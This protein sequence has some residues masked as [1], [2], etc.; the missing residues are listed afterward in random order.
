[1]RGDE[2][3]SLRFIYGRGGSGKSRFCLDD[4][5]RKL[6]KGFDNRLILLVPEQ[7]SF[8]AEKNLLRALGDMGTFKTEVLSFKRMAHRVF[9]EVGGI[10]HKR[11]N[12]SG[13]SMILYKI[14]R[15]RENDLKIFY[16]SSSKQGFIDIV[17]EVIT[18]FKRYNI[19]PELLRDTIEK[20]KEDE[21]ELKYKLE[22]LYRVYIDFE[23]AIHKNYI[24]DE[25][26]LTMLYEK[27]EECSLF[28]GAEVWVDE[29]STFTPQQYS[30]LSRLMKK[31]KRV[32]ISLNMDG[33]S[34]YKEEIDDIFWVAR[35]TERKLL[36]IAEE[37]HVA[38][39]KPIDLNK[40]CCYRF[41]NS[42]D[43]GHMEKYFFK[44]PFVP[45][46]EEP[47]NIRIYKALNNYEEIQWVARNIISKVRDDGYRFRDIAVVC[48]DLDNYKKITRVIFDEYSIPY[49]LDEKRDVRDN[50]LV[51]LILSVF[52]IFN[53]NW[54]YESVFRYLKTGLIDLTNDG[55]EEQL[56]T[57]QKIDILEN[58]VLAHGIKGKKWLEFWE[59]GLSNA[60]DK[61]EYTRDVLN[62]INEIK[63]D[64][65]NPLTTF[66]S[67]VAKKCNMRDLCT[68]V[69]E[70]LCEVG[71]F[72]KVDIWIENFKAEGNTER[73]DEYEQVVDVIF[74]VLD[75]MVEIMGDEVVSLDRFI[76]ILSMGFLKQEVGLIPIALDQVI[77]GDIARIKSHSIKAL[78]IIGVNDGV[79]PRVNREEGILSDNDRG[80]LK[81]EGVT[82]AS[83]TETKMFEENFLIYTTLTMASEYLVL[84]YPIAD[85]EGKAQR[86]SILISRFKKL[87]PKLK[88][89]SDILKNKEDEA[90][91]KIVAPEPTFNELISMMRSYY[92]D[93]EEVSSVW[94]NA[95]EWYKGKEEWNGRIERVLSG[96]KYSNQVQTIRGEKIKALY[97]KPYVFDV[98]RVEKYAQCPFAF[99]IQYGLKAKDRKIYEFGS[100]DFGTFVHEILD[101]FTNK[102][103][104]EGRHW[105][106]LDKK[107]S[108]STISSMID[109]VIK[110]ESILKSSAKYKYLVSK[111][112]R[113]LTKSVSVISEHFKRGS[114]ETLDSEIVFG[115]GKYKPIK[116][117][118]PSGDDIYLRGRVDRVDILEDNGEVYIRIVD[119]KS[120]KKSFSLNEVYYGLQLQ[121]LVYLD[122]I[123]SNEEEI[124]KKDIVPGA[125]L[126]FTIDDPMISSSGELSE[127]EVEQRLI[128]ELKMSG[129]LL[130]DPK[131]I[132]EM[133]KDIK[134][135]SII[136]P[137]YMGK[138]GI[139]ENNSSV[140]TREQF[141]VISEYVRQ[142]VV[143][144]CEDMLK[145]DITIK[146]VKNGKYT[147]CS[148]C[149]FNA[150]CQFDYSLKDNKY[151]LLQKKD[152]EDIWKLMKEKISGEEEL[153][154]DE[155]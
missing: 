104:D 73:A 92:D 15:E 39:D 89:E 49:F 142:K 123:L 52:D 1:M 45:Y 118:L 117:S 86:S 11:L 23:I 99:Y 147:C 137:A 8:E 125:I 66:G 63:D 155:Q 138:D 124:L 101:K 57:K 32:N 75:Q 4:I 46:R 88:E 129:L 60:K 94:K 113:I 133:D 149:R 102:V 59:Y 105:S 44:Y 55:C 67:K 146:P 152:K 127:E 85:F 42:Y 50:P 111:M 90:V 135:Y 81:T 136:I 96:L 9:N 58:F 13:K 5:K 98:S 35:N 41:N 140:A 10:T 115:D 71:A 114:F 56:T 37:N 62:V 80:I 132:K 106:D 33:S 107:W 64:V 34:E 83:D 70:F 148:Y 22:D 154:H 38:Y 14:L 110:D 128:K 87:F 54:S 7:F 53:K 82:L 141:K 95:Y 68:Y 69:Y 145:G 28:N 74:E 126:Y 2:E 17:S 40:D 24:D 122:A 103:K 143:D 121:L 27:L 153:E 93:K 100:P 108:E 21:L 97:D 20:L 26:E 6:E 65:I 16:K 78:Y 79:F 61:Q 25:D 144:L 131:V 48:R 43:I 91:D 72:Q 109:E 76:E 130:K 29:F 77:V 51:V 112:K 151:C 116:L 139:S 3:L 30:I 18:E 84:T 120:G 47:D 119:Y 31:S 36:K 19:T 134:G 150:I 12:D